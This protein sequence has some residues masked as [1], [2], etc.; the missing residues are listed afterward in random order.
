MANTADKAQGEIQAQLT[1]MGD[2]FDGLEREIKENGS[3]FA[4]VIVNY[5]MPSGGAPIGANAPS[6]PQPP[7]CTM[8]DILDTMNTRLQDAIKTLSD[9]RGRCQL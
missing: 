1:R 8:V 9:M 5:N 7:R 2:L 4:S 6:A 3:A